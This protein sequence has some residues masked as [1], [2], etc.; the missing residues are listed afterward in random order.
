LPIGQFEVELR[1]LPD[2]LPTALDRRG[3]EIGSLLVAAGALT[4]DQLDAARCSLRRR[5]ATGSANSSWE[6]GWAT[7]RDV[8]QALAEQAGLEF[9]DLRKVEIDRTAAALLPEKF[10]RRYSALPV[11]F[12]NDTTVL[13]AVADPTDVVSADDLRHAIGLDVELAVVEHDDLET[14]IGHSYRGQVEIIETLDGDDDARAADRRRARRR[15]DERA[16]DP[17]RQ[18]GTRCG[19]RRRR[20]R[21]PLRAA[22]ARA[23]RPR[24]RR[25]SHPSRCLD[26]ESDA[27]PELAELGIPA[28]SPLY[29]AVGCGR[30]G[31]TGYRGR[32][33]LYEVMPIHGRIRRLVEASTEEI[34]AAAV[35]EGMTTLRS[36]G[37]RLCIEGTSSIDEIRRVT[38]DRLV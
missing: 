29:R 18:P 28:D 9:L 31:G 21:H 20:F 27:G 11:L 30:C 10:A 25:R 3:R 33:A 4:H 13:V 2:P 32:V 8:A 16:G 15:V 19:D 34:F 7:P 23:P 5:P 17:A 22:G 37:I 36:D 6:R 24:A 38:G 26:P 14:A 12:L 1:R 35:E